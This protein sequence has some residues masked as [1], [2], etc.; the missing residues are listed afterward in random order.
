M[1]T[2]IVRRSSV[3]QMPKRRRKLNWK[4]RRTAR[5]RETMKWVGVSWSM[6]VNRRERN[7]RPLFVVP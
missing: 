3:M 7:A 1:G 6:P 2:G 4:P 5:E